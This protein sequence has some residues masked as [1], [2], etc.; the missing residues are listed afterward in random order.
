MKS[1]RILV[2]GAGG[3][4]GGAL[5]HELQQRSVQ[6]RLGYHSEERAEQ[7]RNRGLDAVAIDLANPDSLA[8]AL[9]DIEAVFLLGTGIAGQFERELNLVREA[10]RAGVRHLVKLSTWQADAEAYDIARIH[11]AIERAI[12]ATGLSCTFLRPNGFMQNFATHK[13]GLIRR[14]TIAEPAE[15]AR[16]S[17]VD[18]RDVAAVAARALTEPQ[19][20]GQ[21]YELSGPESLTFGEVATLFSR[22]LDRPVHYTALSDVVAR[23]AM[24]ENGMPGFHADA[25]I[26]LN[27]HYRSGAGA[28]VTDAVERVTGRPAIRFERFIADYLSMW[29]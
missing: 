25:L 2:T 11:R 9:A 5:V 8:P 26:D 24:I 18:V 27:R 17:H 10:K 20:A 21:I 4:V 28:A 12:E 7:A 3:T 19:H 13:A 16:V 14:G 6:P 22:V 15:E 23:S 29:R 1:S